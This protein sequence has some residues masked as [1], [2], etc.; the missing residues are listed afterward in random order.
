MWM[1]TLLLLS[2][3]LPPLTQAQVVL[4]RVAS[5]PGDYLLRFVGPLPDLRTDPAAAM[6]RARAGQQARIERLRRDLSGTGLV[7][8]RDLWI[9]N[10]LAITLPSRYLS[11]VQSLDYV[12]EVRPEARYRAEP[13]ALTRLPVSG[14][15]VQDHLPFL[16]LDQLWAD[17]Y[18]GQGVVVAILD[19]G[20]DLTHQDLKGQW[21]GGSN[22]WFDAVDGSQAMPSDIS[23]KGHGTAAAS[24][25]VG[26]NGTGGYLG[27]APAAEWI[28]ARIFDKD[29]QA[30]EAD[31]IAALQWLLDPDG[32]PATKDYP[33]IVSNSWGLSG[34]RQCDNP[35]VTELAAL[36]ALDID[37]VF[38]AGN[39]GPDPSTYVSPAFDSRVISVGALK[40]DAATILPTSSRGPD[41][42]NRE[43]I[44]FLVAP[45]ETIVAADNGG[46]FSPTQ[47]VTGTSFAAPQVSGVLA[48]LRSRYQASK[49]ARKT[50][51][52][53][54]A[55]D[56]GPSGPDPDY[57]HGRVQ[58][59][60]AAQELASYPGVRP[61]PAEVN[62][63]SARYVF[64]ENGGTAKIVLIRSGDLAQAA[65]VTVATGGSSDTAEAGKD[66]TGLTLHAVNFQA[67]E[68]RKEV[69]IEL[70]DDQTAEAEEFFTL[71]MT[72]NNN[73]NIGQRDK[74][75]LWIRD[76]D[77]ATTD[78]TVGGA[79]LD[80]LLLLLLSLLGVMRKR[81]R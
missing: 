13:Q 37:L 17:G 29:K 48:L 46:L 4:D 80:G 72:G 51:L 38:A 67:G 33:D 76:D 20:V 6:A 68:Y 7:I 9:R 56:L 12:L 30:T 25:I 41:R 31:I 53:N 63:S 71:V 24:L 61:R 58:A 74:K 45:G 55:L 60:R 65:S 5:R 43:V 18:R 32:D 35:F 14:E 54:A 3:L 47:K 79:S 69:L 66:Y 1:R 50:A 36:D 78:N 21:R 81:W 2:L 34:T 77:G 11:R 73:V 42:C 52:S 15:T 59:S 39:Y 75:T 8:R 57:G 70:I 44:P 28:A 19:T 27:V 10:S 62:F 49:S 23:G 22:S 64:D 16:D 26:G 40:T